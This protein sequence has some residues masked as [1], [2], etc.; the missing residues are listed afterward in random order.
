MVRHK[1]VAKNLNYLEKEF[2]KFSIFKKIKTCET[3]KEKHLSLE[4]TEEKWRK[5]SNGESVMSEYTS[6][7]IKHVPNLVGC[8]LYPL[9]NETKNT[10]T[11]EEKQKQK[12]KQKQKLLT[13]PKGEELNENEK[14][15]GT[16][17]FPKQ[18][19]IEE[20]FY[21]KEAKKAKNYFQDWI[22]ELCEGK[23]LNM[24]EMDD[25]LEHVE[26]LKRYWN[27]YNNPNG[28][29]DLTNYEKMLLGCYERSLMDLID[30]EWPLEQWY[31]YQ[32]YEYH[33][34]SSANQQQQQQQ[35][36]QQCIT[37][38]LKQHWKEVYLEFIPQEIQFRLSVIMGITS[39]W[40]SPLTKT[41]ALAQRLSGQHIQD[42]SLYKI[43]WNIVK[44]E[45]FCN[46]IDITD[47]H[48]LQKDTVLFANFLDH[49]KMIEK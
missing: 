27:S 30:V 19:G 13:R 7:D 41:K 29:S 46:N 23:G 31:R 4:S 8:I 48:Q 1:C 26:I 6:N 37:T 15:K 21:L 49:S 14:E 11:E 34:H 35:Q 43:C 17:V 16:N 5:N 47:I 24:N 40:T 25:S 33:I 2:K 32:S 3:G 28:L 44:I 20:S 22:E 36:Q 42:V 45:T 12:Q 10:R 18:Y 38:E 9:L 39:M